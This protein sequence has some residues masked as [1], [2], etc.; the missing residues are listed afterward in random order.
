M[1]ARIKGYSIQHLLPISTYSIVLYY[2]HVEKYHC[3]HFTIFYVFFCKKKGRNS[4]FCCHSSIKITS[5]VLSLASVQ[6]SRVNHVSCHVSSPVSC[7]VSCLMSHLST[8]SLV[9]PNYNDYSF[10]QRLAILVLVISFLF[11]CCFVYLLTYL[12]VS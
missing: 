12:L 6:L 9:K 5:L 11:D 1:Y 4:V 2:A 8:A 3:H 10:L 7:H